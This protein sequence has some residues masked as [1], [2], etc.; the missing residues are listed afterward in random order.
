MNK[1]R[2]TLGIKS[3]HTENKTMNYYAG[4]KCKCRIANFISGQ[5]FLMWSTKQLP[6]LLNKFT[7]MSGNSIR[8]AYLGRTGRTEVCDIT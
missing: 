5:F 4:I 8:S 1:T 2:T 7:G 3:F 6:S